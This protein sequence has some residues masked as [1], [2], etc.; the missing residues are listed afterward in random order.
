MLYAIQYAFLNAMTG[1]CMNLICMVRNFIFN[2]YNNRKVPIYWLIIVL[3]V[4]VGVSLTT[5][6]GVISLLPMLAVVIYSVAVWYGNLK[7][8]RLTEICSCF[9][10]IIYNINVLALTGLLATI[11]EMIGALFAFYKY[12]LKR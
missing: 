5:Y 11:V 8:I 4:M 9:L 2:K 7:I 10:Y 1:C 12:D 3:F 6:D